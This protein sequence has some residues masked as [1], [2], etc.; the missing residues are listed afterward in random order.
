[1]SAIWFLLCLTL[2]TLV[3]GALVFYVLRTERK[4]SDE[5][6]STMAQ[7]VALKMSLLEAAQARQEDLL[8]SAREQLQNNFRSSQ[9]FLKET[10]ATAAKSM[11]Q[12]NLISMNGLQASETSTMKLLSSTVAM[13]GTKDTLAYHQVQ[14]TAFTPD[15]GSTSYTAVDDTLVAELQ[16][17]QDLA[18]QQ[19]DLDAAA[20]M[21]ERMGVPSG[22]AGFN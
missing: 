20:E 18:N 7:T 13:L 2:I 6:N 14:G 3:M 4:R 11:E 8:E 10:L 9:E 19:L 5:T 17:Q 12:A 21:L 22:S 1:M 16:Q 15:D